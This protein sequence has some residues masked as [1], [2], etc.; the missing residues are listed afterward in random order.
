MSMQVVNDNGLE[1][2]IIMNDRQLSD[3]NKEFIQLC[4]EIAST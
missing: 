2:D 3:L 1:I 4:N